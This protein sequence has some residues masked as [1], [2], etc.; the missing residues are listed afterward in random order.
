VGGA[1]AGDGGSG[2]TGVGLGD[3]VGNGAGVGVGA[4]EGD[5]LG[6]GVSAKAAG[7]SDPPQPVAT[8][9]ANAARN[10]AA[11]RE[12]SIAMGNLPDAGLLSRGR[13]GAIFAAQSGVTG[14]F[15]PVLRR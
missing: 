8:P 7:V 12:L 15:R 3:G 4:G 14:A 10:S 9:H 6:P 11:R 13:S 1:G 2:G 5:G